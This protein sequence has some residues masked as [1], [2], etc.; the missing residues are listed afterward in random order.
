MKKTCK[1]SA[2]MMKC[3]E[4][5][6]SWFCQTFRLSGSPY[7]KCITCD[8]NTE[9]Y[10]ILKF[11]GNDVNTAFAVILSDSGEVKAFPLCRIF[12]VREE[13]I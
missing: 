5:L 9:R 12:N 2:N 11:G 1:V 3:Q 10:E 4:C 7:S 13:I 6:N 8:D